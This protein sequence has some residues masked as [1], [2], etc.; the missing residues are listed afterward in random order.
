MRGVLILLT[1]LSAC[2]SEP[3]PRFRDPTFAEWR[4]AD[5]GNVPANYDAAIRTHLEGVLRDPR[6]ATITVIGGPERTWIGNAPRFQ[7]GYG[8]CVTLVERSVYA[9]YTDF[10]PTFFLLKDGAVTHMR[11]GS[12]GERI[13][14]RLER[15]PEG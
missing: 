3:D 12:D 1:L 15:N 6:G 10:G 5:F 9:P 7:Y 14:A 4:A 2:A 8:V 11:E 13:C